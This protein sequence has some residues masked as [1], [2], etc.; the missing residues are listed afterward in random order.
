MQPVGA[1][2]EPSDTSIVSDYVVGNTRAADDRYW[3]GALDCPKNVTMTE[4]P[5]TDAEEVAVA[6]DDVQLIASEGLAEWLVGQKVSLAFGTPPAKLWMVGVDDDGQ[7]AVFDRELDKVMGLASDSTERL[8]V[9]TR[10]E[11]WRFENVLAPGA[12]TDDGHDRLFVPRR[13]STVGNVNIHDVGI[14]E[15]GRDLWVNTRFGCLASTSD[16]ASFVP[17]WHPPFLS[18]P[19]Q[20]DRCHLNGLAMVEGVAAYVTCVSNTTEVDGWRNG[21]RDQ[22][23][24]IDV[25][26]GELVAHGLSMPHSPRWREGRLWVANAGTGELGTINLESGIFE[27]LMFGPDFLR[28]LCFVGDYA[29]VGSSKPRRGGIYSG[30]ALDDALEARGMEPHLGIF[31]VDVRSGDLVHWLLVE[32]QVRE[33]FDVCALPGVRRPAVIGLLGGEVRSDLWFNDELPLPQ[34]AGHD[35][36]DAR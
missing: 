4:T 1:P 14:E 19:Q 23:I 34:G 7:L 36:V 20:G 24:V 6:Q 11:V 22:G 27:P 28:G 16:S 21:R 5:S 31:I 30:L 10:Y 12:L 26:S 15:D 18:G 33:L 25:A 3:R 9:A 29:V 2:G 8:W 35:L 17:R 32:G 13:M